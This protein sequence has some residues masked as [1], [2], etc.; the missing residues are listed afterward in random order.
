[1]RTGDGWTTCAS[2]HR[3]WGRYG[4]AGLLIID[5]ERVILQH[6]APWTHEGDSW[7]VLGGARDE[8][9]SALEAALREAHEEAGIEAATVDPIAL[10]VDDHD[11]WSYTTVV[12]RPR[13]PIEPGAINA[14]SLSVQWHP[15][16]DVAG[17]RL[18]SGFQAAWEH[19]R[20]VPAKLFLIADAAL[21]GDPLLRELVRDGV[22]VNRLPQG[23]TSGGF[24]RLV[25]ELVLLSPDMALAEA[26]VPVGAQVLR[27]GT[28]DELLRIA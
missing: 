26:P 4:A 9:E 5:D 12:A 13:V 6:R 16:D 15:I 20:A 28:R 2:G 22:L 3:H 1:M 21:S 25:P 7:G 11:G 8:H 19:L 24:T 27:A 17:L 10:Y 23:F 18:H 14:E